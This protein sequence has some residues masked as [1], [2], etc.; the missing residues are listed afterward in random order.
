MRST[1]KLDTALLSFLVCGLLVLGQSAPPSIMGKTPAQILSDN[2]ANVAL[3]VSSDGDSSSLGT[4]F[5]VGDGSML[6]TNFHVVK[7]ARKLTVKLAS[8]KVLEVKTAV[9]FD[10]DEDIAVLRISPRTDHGLQLGDSDT[11]EVGE[12]VVVISNPEGLDHTVSNG[13]I[14]GIRRLQNWPKILQISAPISPGS[15]GGPVFNDRGQ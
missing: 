15:S 6:V 2:G 12:P 10:A 5:L 13:L 1:I 4:G 8:G 9:G 7:G 3:I 11:L 14:S